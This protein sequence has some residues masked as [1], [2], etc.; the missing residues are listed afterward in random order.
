M[1]TALAIGW[2]VVALAATLVFAGSGSS[3]PVSVAD[4]APPAVAYVIPSYERGP[5]IIHV[6]QPDDARGHRTSNVSDEDDEEVAPPPR[7]R[8][9]P[10][11]RTTPRWPPQPEIARK[12]VRQIAI[13]KSRPI[14]PPAP[15]PVSQPPGPRRA[16]LS[17]PPPPAEGPTPIRPTPNFGAKAQAGEQFAAPREPAITEDS[18]PAGYSPPASQSDADADGVK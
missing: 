3:Q 10:P 15:R 2:L 14:D 12:P 17:A 18:P 1:K 8:A 16:I 5:R 11:P 6:P 9:A 4:A 13:T 7:R